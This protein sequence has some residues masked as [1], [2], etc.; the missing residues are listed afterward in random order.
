[1]SRLFRP[2]LTL[3][4]AALIATLALGARDTASA[5][6]SWANYHWARTANPFTL[7]LGDNV[8]GAWDSYLIVASSDWSQSAVLDTVVAAGLGGT[9]CKARTGRIEVC[10]KKY[11]YNG[12]L[13]LAQIY[14]SGDHITKATAKMNDSYFN[15]PSYNTPA[16]RQ[17]VMCQEVAHGF[18]LDHQDEA[19]DNPNLGTCMDY[20]DDPTAN[21]HPNAHDYEQ[22]ELIYGH[23]DSASTIAPVSAQ[24]TGRFSAPSDEEGHDDW[25]QPTG[26]DVQGRDNR[27]EKVL[28]N[29]QRVVTHVLWAQAGPGK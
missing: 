8:S 16:W 25:G 22:L 15:L 29:G 26:K 1:M 7:T 10:N 5:S 24:S 14:I 21:Q 19:F 11:G 20:T 17:M 27:F 9:N 2:V 12:W 23:L 18:G 4:M 6:H 3:T 13:G 28:G